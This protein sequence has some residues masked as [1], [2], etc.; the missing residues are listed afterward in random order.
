MS[1]RLSRHIESFE[2][3]RERSIKAVLQTQGTYIS[4]LDMRKIVT[5][6][7]KKINMTH[8][9]EYIQMTFKISLNIIACR[10][11]K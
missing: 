10:Q 6:H 1:S 11:Y 4:I 7:I 5:T 9:R 2:Y 3:I 8:K